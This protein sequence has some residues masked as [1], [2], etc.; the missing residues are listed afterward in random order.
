MAEF[1]Q[2][3]PNP[4]AANASSPAATVQLA[5]VLPSPPKLRLRVSCL[6]HTTRLMLLFAVAAS[7]GARVAG[8]KNSKHCL[9][10]TFSVTD[11]KGKW[12][13]SGSE[14]HSVYIWHLNNK[15]ARRSPT[16]GN[17]I[18]EVWTT[19]TECETHLAASYDPS[20]QRPLGLLIHLVA[21]Q[22]LPRTVRQKCIWLLFCAKG[23]CRWSAVRPAC[24]WLLYYPVEA[25]AAERCQTKMHTATACVRQRSGVVPPQVVQVLPGRDGP[26]EPGA[27]HCDAVLAVAC[28]P[29]KSMIASGAL[30][31]DCTIKLWT[32]ET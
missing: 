1:A 28:H 16:R 5:Q 17:Q 26:E 27:G 18:S 8:H 29:K 7:S 15:Q 9:F 6:K 22:A 2:A 12:V 10:A 11:R 14:D 25:C 4:Q 21:G 24:I 3:L 23:L 31:R 13:V 20:G 19:T 32:D 30:G